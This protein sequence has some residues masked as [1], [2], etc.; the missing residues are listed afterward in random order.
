MVVIL[1]SRVE[2]IRV[3]ATLITTAFA[4]AAGMAWNQAI[5]AVFTQALGPSQGV[6]ANIIYALIVT[7]VAVTVTTILARAAS[8]AAG[9]EITL[10]SLG[11]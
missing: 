9:E 2:Y 6:T 8:K 1:V 4:V 10:R 11:I 7:V 3:T 5:V